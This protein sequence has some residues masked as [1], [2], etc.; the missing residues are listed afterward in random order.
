M[1][2]RF[3]LTLLILLNII[4]M[5][6]RAEVAHMPVL[7]VAVLHSGT[8]NWELQHLKD[9]SLDTQNGFILEL[10]KVAS[11]SAA[12][13]ALTSDSTDVIVSDWLWAGKRNQDGASLRFIPFSSQVG[14]VVRKEAE[15]LSDLTAL[16]GKTIGVAG[17]PLNKSWILLQAAAKAQGVELNKEATIQFGAPPLLSQALKRG[18]LDLLL[19][20]WHYTAK[21]EV[22]GYHQVLSLENLMSEMGMHSRVPMLGYLFNAEFEK[23]NPQLISGFAK[24]LTQTKSQ[25]LTNDQYWESLKPLMKAGT[26][27]V[28]SALKAG[29]RKGVPEVMTSLH[30]EDAQRFYQL[31]DKMQ[32]FPEGG[33]LG[34][35]VFYGVAPSSEKGSGAKE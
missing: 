9:Q 5:P 13:L 26:P 24:A 3:C 17:G 10:N 32:P 7:R 20:F 8:V 12:R 6:V 22:E 11:L 23:E 31:I 15:L 2:L 21:L 27:E 34:S 19:T 4:A 33:A 16:R 29:Y 18:Q 14:G 30:V 28:F 35:D 25:L 1:N